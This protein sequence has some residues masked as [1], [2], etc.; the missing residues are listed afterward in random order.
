M[1]HSNQ[2]TYY[3]GYNGSSQIKYTGWTKASVFPQGRFYHLTIVY[4]STGSN[5]GTFTLY[6]NG[7]EKT[8][9][10]GWTFTHGESLG[11]HSLGRGATNRPGTNDILSFRLWSKNLSSDQVQENYDAQ[12]NKINMGT[13][14]V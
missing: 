4:E 10:F 13:Y 12:K 11:L 14:P 9:T 1:F 3:E 8:T 6:K 2:L 7:N 5:Q